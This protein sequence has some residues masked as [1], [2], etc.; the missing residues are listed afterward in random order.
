MNQ[1][2]GQTFTLAQ[3]A[4]MGMSSAGTI[5]LVFDASETGSARNITIQQLVLSFYSADG[6]TAQHH[7]YMGPSTVQG[8]TGSGGQGYYFQLDWDQAQA[9]QLAFFVGAG[10]DSNNR[11]GFSAWLTDADGGQDTI[12]VFPVAPYPVPEPASFLM[13]GSG[14]VGFGLL[15]RRYSKKRR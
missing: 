1:T 5:G 4:A 7:Y 11:I 6:L 14:L 2:G 10:Y 9:A 15:L 13:M 8:N 12:F 3:L